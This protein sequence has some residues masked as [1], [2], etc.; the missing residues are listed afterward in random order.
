LQARPQ[1][2]V[3]QLDSIVQAW[4]TGDQDQVAKVL[5]FDKYSGTALYQRMLVNRNENWATELSARLQQ[6]GTSFVSVG[7]AHMLGPKGLPALLSA[8]G[9]TVSRVAISQTEA[10]STRSGAAT[11]QSSPLPSAQPSAS[12][13]PIPQFVTPPPGWAARKMTISQGSMRTDMMWFDPK[14]RG[15]MLA[16]HIDV[17]AGVAA[18]NLDTFDALF[19]QGLL[20][21]NTVK[22]LQPSKRVKICNG[23]QDGTLTVIVSQKV[24]EEI[25]LAMSDRGYVAQ[26]MRRQG[27]PEDPVAARALLSLCAPPLAA[28]R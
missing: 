15:A 24:V 18:F 12:P 1:S 13:T 26:Y 19:Q 5:Q 4:Q 16:A 8:K 21:D 10:V 14:A 3:S 25:A 7:A 23:T 22:V 11:L 27:M 28:T 6:P 20:A 2:G 9:F 17:P